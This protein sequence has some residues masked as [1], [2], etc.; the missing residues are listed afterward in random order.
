MKEASFMTQAS[1]LSIEKQMN[2]IIITYTEAGLAIARSM[3]ASFDVEIFYKDKN[4]DKI[5]EERWPSLETIIFISATGIAVR[6]I[7]PLIKDK[8]TDP[9]VLVIDDKAKHVISLLSGHIGGANELAIDIA[10][11]INAEPVI[12]TASDNRGLEALDIYLRDNDFAYNS[13]EALTKIMAAIVNQREI[14]L[15]AASDFDFKYDKFT[16]DRSEADYAIIQDEGY[17]TNDEENTLYIIKKKYN[18]G[19]GL[20]R[21][22]DFDV[23]EEA[24]HELLREMDI[25]PKAIKRF[26]SIDIKKDEE[27]LLELCKKYDRELIFYTAD[28]LN[29]VDVSEKSDFVKEIT[30]A[31]SVSEA[32]AKLLG[33]KIILTKKIID[34]ITFSITEEI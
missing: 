17:M 11:A 16:S 1:R 3:A 7:A 27:A 6:K 8:Y 32:A 34:S 10:K 14:Y 30:G 2:K 28:E 20:R 25:N 18:M 4:I 31:Y 13:R 29:E 33:G 22:T 23:L 5:L 12:T 19:I 21:G 26:G 15:E 9:A 24:F